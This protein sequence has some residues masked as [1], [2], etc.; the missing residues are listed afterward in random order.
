MPVGRTGT[1]VLGTGLWLVGVGLIGTL[2]GLWPIIERTH[3]PD[4]GSTAVRL[5]GSPVTFT[6]TPDTALLALVVVASAIGGFVH[7]ATS[8]S[9]Y[10]GNRRLTR[11]WLWWYLL[12]APIGVALAVLFYFALRAGLLST[13]VP[14]QSINPYGVGALAALVG[15]FSK[16]ATDKLR[17]VFETMFRTAEGYGDDERKDKA[18][19]PRPLIVGIVPPR[20][21]AGS[22][23]L[24]LDLQG[25]GFIPSSVVQVGRPDRPVEAIPRTMTY[26]SPTVLRVV[27]DAEDVAE[28]G[29]LEIVVVNPE[30]G[31]GRSNPVT[32][33]VHDAAA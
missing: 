30:P 16:Q 8:F 17:E 20:L 19:N 29:T 21:P 5:F 22:D 4:A 1:I 7:T 6:F 14:S 9:T 15:L 11:S 23:A 26:D 10:V 18:T 25:Y 3:R 31:G 28:V 13:Q 2:V 32:V 24:I 27:L 33:D 12:R